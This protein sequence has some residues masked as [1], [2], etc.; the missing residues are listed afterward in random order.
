M[1][2]ATLH[3]KNDS[4]YIC[5]YFDLIMSDP[6]DGKTILYKSTYD[7]ILA[8]IPNDVLVIISD[9]SEIDILKDQLDYTKKPKHEKTFIYSI[10]NSINR[11][12]KAYCSPVS[13]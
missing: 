3:F 13:R 2:I 5:I 1:K 4:R 12:R 6:N 10:Y 7:N 9:E 8:V 11:L